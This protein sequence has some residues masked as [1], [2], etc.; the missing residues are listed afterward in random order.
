M[1]TEKETRAEK[2]KAFSN[3]A[4]LQRTLGSPLGQL[5]ALSNAS[6]SQEHSV[7]PSPL[8]APREEGSS[9]RRGLAGSAIAV[10][11]LGSQTWSSGMN[12]AF[13]LGKFIFDSGWAGEE[14]SDRKGRDGPEIVWDCPNTAGGPPTVPKAAG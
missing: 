9:G 2:M 3:T 5:P 1:E 4:I 8:I 11:F 10:C 6:P 12:L 7:A 13:I 14:V